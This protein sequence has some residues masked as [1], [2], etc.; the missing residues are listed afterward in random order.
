MSRSE[1]DWTDFLNI[2]LTSFRT[3]EGNV[4]DLKVVS[5]SV[6]DNV[7]ISELELLQRQIDALNDEV[8][9]PLKIYLFNT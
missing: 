1:D 6:P 3:I 8:W 9:E 5:N 7:Q 4:L 2:F